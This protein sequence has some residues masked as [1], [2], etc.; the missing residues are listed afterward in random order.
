MLHTTMKLSNAKAFVEIARE[1]TPF[2]GELQTFW[3]SQ[4]LAKRLLSA[5]LSVALR[6]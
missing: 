6:S 2:I 3:S 5:V 1:D 4:R